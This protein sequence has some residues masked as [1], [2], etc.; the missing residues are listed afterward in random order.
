MNL[1]LIGREVLFKANRGEII[2]FCDCYYLIEFFD[3]NVDTLKIYQDEIEF[4]LV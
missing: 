1:N 3:R 2:D 4:Y